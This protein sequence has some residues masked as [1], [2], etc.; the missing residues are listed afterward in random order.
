MKK[1]EQRKERLLRELKEQEEKKKQKEKIDIARDY[2]FYTN[3]YWNVIENI[4]LIPFHYEDL[5]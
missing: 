5:Y 1:E 3:Y 2:L 4:S